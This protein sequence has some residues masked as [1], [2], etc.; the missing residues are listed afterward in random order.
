M[1][2]REDIRKAA[3]IE[4]GIFQLTLEREKEFQALVNAVSRFIEYHSSAFPGLFLDAMKAAL[5]PFQV[6]I[7]ERL[8]HLIMILKEN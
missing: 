8:L 6:T 3:A 7:S 2:T 4:D 1:I 5:K